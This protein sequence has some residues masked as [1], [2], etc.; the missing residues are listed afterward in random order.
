MNPDIIVRY[1][2]HPPIEI[3]LVD[4]P[5][6]KSYKELVQRNLAQPAM[7]RDPAKYTIEHFKTLCVRARDELGWDWVKDQYDLPVTTQLHKDIEIFLAQGFA[8]IPEQYDEL[9]HEL[10]YALHAIQGN[11]SRG[12]WLQVEWFNDD[13]IPMADDFEFTTTLKRGDVKLQNPFTGHDPSF[14]FRQRDSSAIA[15]TCKFHDWIR[16]GLNIMIRDQN[17]DVPERYLDFFAANAPD[18]YAQQGREKILRY[19]GWPRIGHVLNLHAVESV[20]NS[21]QFEFESI[22]VV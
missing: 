10:H 14:V 20:A 6:A 15:Q 21:E 12:D 22:E 7:S 5:L 18:W 16:P 9:L 3:K 11:N 17:F 8:S 1:K 2:N 13:G 19:T 4:H